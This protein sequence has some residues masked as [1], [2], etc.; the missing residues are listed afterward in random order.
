M[1]FFASSLN[2]GVQLGIGVIPLNLALNLA[3]TLHGVLEP[4]PINKGVQL[5][6]GLSHINLTA[7]FVLTLFDLALI[8]KPLLQ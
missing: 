4:M 7:F 5:L 3:A 1:Q 6:V 2:Q 8:G